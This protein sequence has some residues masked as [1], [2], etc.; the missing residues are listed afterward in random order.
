[1][2][3]YTYTTPPTTV[4]H[5]PFRNGFLLTDTVGVTV[6]KELGVWSTVS[7]PSSTRLADADVYYLGGHEHV[8]TDAEKT[9][10][11]SGSVG[12]SFELIT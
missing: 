11:E 1:M 4:V 7:L 9:D 6:I 8:V 5:D 3:S 2:A 12:G 10:I